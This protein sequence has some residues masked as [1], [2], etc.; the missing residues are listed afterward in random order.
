MNLD[1]LIEKKP[2]EAQPAAAINYKSNFSDYDSLLADLSRPTQ[3]QERYEAEPGTPEPQN[4]PWN[5]LAQPDETV[6]TMD[7]E[8][9]LR[10]GQ[11]TAKMID[12][13]LA[14]GASAIAKESDISKYKASKGD[15]DD[16]GEAWAEIAEEYNFN[17]NPW[18]K[19]LILTG[20][21]YAPKYIQAMNDRRF[22][23]L[24]ARQHEQEERISRMEA[25]AA[26]KPAEA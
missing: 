7:P 12:G 16:L 1:T 19:I 6:Q 3:N 4:Q 18:V 21:T 5:P 2:V 24:E 14:F 25:A 10:A 20:T 17:V 22:K 9:A 13:A 8:K 23:I 15:V 26:S 11:R